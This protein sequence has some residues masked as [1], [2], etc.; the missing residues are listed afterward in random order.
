VRRM[1]G[2]DLVIVSA[3]PLRTG[4]EW[5]ERIVGSR[6]LAVDIGARDLRLAV[7]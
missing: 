5:P 4:R 1:A 6:S 7:A 3:L 2:V